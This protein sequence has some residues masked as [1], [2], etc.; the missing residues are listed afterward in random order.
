MTLVKA[1]VFDWAGTVIGF[2]SRAPMVAIVEAFKEF[3][4]FLTV[5]EARRPMGLPKRDHIRAVGDLARIDE[6]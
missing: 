6:A 3:G 2:G 5:A 4:I 1:V